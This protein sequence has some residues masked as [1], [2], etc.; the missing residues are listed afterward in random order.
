MFNQELPTSSTTK[1]VTATALSGFDLFFGNF[2]R[3]TVHLPG[4]R[5]LSRAKTGLRDVSISRYPGEE[6]FFWSTI[7]SPPFDPTIINLRQA[8]INE[9]CKN[10]RYTKGIHYDIGSRQELK[11]NLDM[12]FSIP[13]SELFKKDWKPRCNLEILMDK[14]GVTATN[15]DEKQ[16]E[17]DDQEEEDDFDSS[18]SS[19]SHGGDLKKPSDIIDSLNSLETLEQCIKEAI[20]N[21]SI[22]NDPN[23]K[24]ISVS[25]FASAE[26]LGE[27]TPARIMAV[28]KD[29]GQRAELL[30][31]VADFNA[32]LAKF[33][34]LCAFADLSQ[35]DKYCLCTF[36]E[37]EDDFY[38]E[39]WNML[40]EKNGH[41]GG[42]GVDDVAPQVLED[43]PSSKQHIVICGSNDAGKSFCGE[44]DLIL[45]LV[46]QS[47]GLAPAEQANIHI[48]D[49]FIR[50]D[51]TSPAP[52]DVII[53]GDKKALS[54]FAREVLVRKN[55]Y[56]K[57]GK[58]CRWYSDEAWTT[59]S[60]YDGFRLNVAEAA[61]LT[62]KKVRIFTIT[63]ST[64]ALEYWST[65]ADISIHHF[66]FDESDA[67]NPRSTRKLIN[68][69]DTSHS[70]EVALGF[71]IDPE[72][73]EFGRRYLK[74]EYTVEPPGERKIE[75]RE[76]TAAERERLKQYPKSLRSLV[77]QSDE[78]VGEVDSNGRITSV[79]LTLE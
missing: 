58:R 33:G 74:G 28:A 1:Q 4:F 10:S 34:M 57:I 68:G 72:F 64:K 59:T 22:F 50:V 7:E 65:Q 69:I 8:L 38:Q 19:Y 79:R 43:S 17:L 5:F 18:Q 37:S 40:R 29:Q 52:S 42:I 46:A 51:R 16:L 9:L 53:N 61:F 39:A 36:D 54:D 56:P 66:Q 12:L 30:R 75:V 47:F 60:S 45:R 31:Q 26:A 27:M 77:P 11:N 62:S 55:A 67:K 35:R 3:A 44:R 73:I 25:L 70:F 49:S 63:H 41:K 78:L 21:I 13:E 20:K 48:A 2:D 6:G 71:G 24:A 14:H 32:Q 23:L 15:L 76:H